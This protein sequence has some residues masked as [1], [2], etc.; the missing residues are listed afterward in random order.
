MSEPNGR[1]CAFEE[2]YKL[3]DNSDI[4]DTATETETTKQ[5][6]RCITAFS[7]GTGLAGIV[8]YGYKSLLSEVFGLDFSIVTFSAVLF[9]VGYYST[10]HFGL[11]EEEQN[12]SE[13]V[14]TCE[15]YLPKNQWK[16]NA[17]I[18][19]IGHS[20]T[21]TSQPKNVLERN[22]VQLSS[23]ERF[24]VVL[25]LWPYTIPL[26][27]V[28]AAEYML[29]VRHRIEIS[30]SLIECANLLINTFDRLEF[31]VLLDFQYRVRPREHNSTIMPIGLIKL[32]FSYHD[33]PG[34]C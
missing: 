8:G 12:E 6:N 1:N 26:F 22:K 10:F 19:M 16:E 5:L 32:A 2:D 25:S 14:K 18:E 29:Q 20:L 3:N 13:A 11:L 23:Q 17:V 30:T 4:K 9:A 31:G 34:T 7:S 15:A 33:H 27:T 24:K 28:Y 21:T